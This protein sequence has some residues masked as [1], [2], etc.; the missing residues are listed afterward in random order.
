MILFL[1]S[2]QFQKTRGCGLGYGASRVSIFRVPD[3]LSLKI[4]RARWPWVPLSLET[5]M[6]GM[7]VRAW[8]SPLGEL[9]RVARG[10][11]ARSSVNSVVASPDQEGLER[12]SA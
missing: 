6:P 8:E 2:E 5:L 10:A 12:R 3:W 1:L 7:R 9:G 11:S 4:E